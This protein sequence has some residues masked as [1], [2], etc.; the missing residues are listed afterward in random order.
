MAP[1][2]E[3]RHGTNETKPGADYTP[4]VCENLAPAFMLVYRCSA[5][6]LLLFPSVHC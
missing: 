5:K 2:K 6:V 4:L 3:A 1:E